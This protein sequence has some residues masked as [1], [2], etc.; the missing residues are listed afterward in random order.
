MEQILNSFARSLLIY[1]GTPMV[2]AKLWNRW[3]I[4]QIEK[5]V[6]KKTAMVP[7]NVSPDVVTNLMREKQPVWTIVNRLA[8]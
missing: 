5:Q 7:N 8:R 2:A 4:E 3:D 1:I 6:F